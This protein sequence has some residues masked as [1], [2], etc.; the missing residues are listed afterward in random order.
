MQHHTLGVRKELRG[1]TGNNHKMADHSM[2]V[3]SGAANEE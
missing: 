1:H 2:A 3:T